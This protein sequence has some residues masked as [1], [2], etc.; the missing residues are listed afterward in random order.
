M[1]IAPTG[2]ILATS[3]A[4]NPILAALIFVGLWD[5]FGTKFTQTAS[6]AAIT[7]LRPGSLS[8]G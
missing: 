4:W 8:S 1:H 3:R 2:P 7:R 6:Q 5:R